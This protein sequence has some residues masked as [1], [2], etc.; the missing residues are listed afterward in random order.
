MNSHQPP[1]GSAHRA[2]QEAQEASI[3][4]FALTLLTVLATGCASPP[5]TSTSFADLMGVSET[6]RA[7]L[8]HESGKGINDASVSTEVNGFV[9]YSE[10]G[11]YPEQKSLYITKNGI[12]LAV[13]NENEIQQFNRRSAHLPSVARVV[14]RDN[15]I[16]YSSSTHTFEDLGLDGMDVRYTHTNAG[17]RGILTQGDGREAT[18]G[19][20]FAGC[21]PLR[22]EVPQLACCHRSGV[23]TAWMFDEV[24]GWRDLSLRRPPRDPSKTLAEQCAVQF[25]SGPAR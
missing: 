17:S 7:M 20:D 24:R 6:D 4:R 10:V 11:D 16:R 15:Y 13:V 21:R 18:Y 3:R 8:R 9:I 25:P 14:A 23:H 19:G 22:A 2:A 5:P 1:R 12:L